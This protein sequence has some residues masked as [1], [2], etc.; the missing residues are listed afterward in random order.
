M[1]SEKERQNLIAHRATFPHGVE[2]LHDPLLNKGTAFSEGERDAL[3]LRGLVPPRVFSQEEQLVRIL[4]NARK[5]PS[6][7]EKYIYMASLQDRNSTLFY[8]AIIDNMDE[9]MPII[10]TPTVGQA[11]Q[12]Y[13]HILRKPRGL[14]ISIEDR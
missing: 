13:G 2:L 6:P 1:L 4:E 7:L 5:K 3:G 9:M 12:E 14:Y 10:Y 8:R 11:C